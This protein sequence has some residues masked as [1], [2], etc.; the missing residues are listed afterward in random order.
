LQSR[1]LRLRERNYRC[2]G[3]EID[4]IMDD[5]AL[6]VFIEVRSRA[7]AAYGGALA[8]LDQHKRRRVSRCAR[9][10]LSTHPH[11]WRRQCR[12]DAVLIEEGGQLHWIKNAWQEE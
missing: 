5:G 8:S 2:R 7:S 9:R 10:Y 4:L 11:A 3:G 6:L 1:G 12:F